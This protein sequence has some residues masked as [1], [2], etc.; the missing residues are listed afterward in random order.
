MILKKII[1]K[2][3][4]SVIEDLNFH[5][6]RINKIVQSENGL[7]LD[8]EYYNWE[9]CE[10]NKNAPWYLIKFV[11][12]KI[13]VFEFYN[14]DP[15]NFSY[16][17][18]SAEYD[19]YLKDILETKKTDIFFSSSIQDEIDN[20][21][22]FLSVLFSTHSSKDIELGYNGY[23]KILGFNCTIKKVIKRKR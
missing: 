3:F 17:I 11:F 18:D 9:D 6:C 4:K 10:N 8:M 23:L 14:P 19:V 12:D 16:E 2:N 13:L 1:G 7:S 20:S 15:G 21:I 22:N 5:D